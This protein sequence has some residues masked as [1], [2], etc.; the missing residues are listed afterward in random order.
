LESD[1]ARIPVR[2][3]AEP[4]EVA[5]AAGLRYAGDEHAGFS[6]KRAGGRFVYLDTDRKIIRDPVILA[7]IR[8]IVI[9]PAWTDVWI[10][11]FSDG[12]VQASGRDARG[13]KQYKYHPLFRAFRESNKYQHMMTF[14]AALPR[15]RATVEK[16]MRLRGLPREKVLA[17]VIHLLETT[18]I[19][20]GNVDYARTNGSFGLTTLKSRHVAVNGAQL[21]FDFVGKSGKQWSVAV[22]DR[23]AAKL[24]KA[25]QDLPGQELLQYL[26]EA[27]RRRSVTSGDVNDYL[28]EIGGPNITAKD[29]RTFGGTVLAASALIRMEPFSSITQAKRN[30]RAAV[31]LVAAGLGNTPAICRKC[32]IH[33]ELIDGYLDG[34][35]RLDIERR[36][37][38]EPH[39]HPRLTAEEAALLAFLRKRLRRGGGAPRRLKQP[40]ARSRAN[41]PQTLS[42]RDRHRRPNL[43]QHHVQIRR[44]IAALH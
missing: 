26:D 23:R 22:T 13:R 33:P 11:R 29:F 31:A 3:E 44:P 35:L 1:L 28:R 7:R 21:K 42:G 24:I 36:A 38:R 25:C 39:K 5:H 16:H 17:T 40:T 19:R 37:R 12:H 14:A 20:V 34:T 41:A 9:P 43:A 6:R 4:R 15:I 18:L 10:S 8:R 27:G 32:Y 30:I 2:H